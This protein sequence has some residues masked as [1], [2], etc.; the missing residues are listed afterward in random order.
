MLRKEHRLKVRRLFVLGAGASY[1]VTSGAGASRERQ[2]P[3][4]RDF[5]ARLTEVR[6]VK[7]KW[8]E[9]CREFAEREWLDERQFSS[10]GLEQA[11]LCQLGHLEFIGAI[12]PRRR[13]TSLTDFGYMNALSHLICFLLRRARENTNG[14]YRRFADKVFPAGTTFDRIQDRVVTYNY[15]ELL[16]KHLFPR[17]DVRAI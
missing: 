8:V 7:P 15:D 2:A 11:I 13:K 6:A 12:H 17:F 4:D 14:A 1:R 3:L 9:A 16:E 5:C 10:F